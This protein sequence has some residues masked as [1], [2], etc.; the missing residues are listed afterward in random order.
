VLVMCTV[1]SDI[2]GFGNCR[3]SSESRLSVQDAGIAL[4]AGS[5]DRRASKTDLARQRIDAVDRD[6][7]ATPGSPRV[8]AQRQHRVCSSAQGTSRRWWF[9]LAWDVIGQCTGVPLFRRGNLAPGFAPSCH[10]DARPN[11]PRS[12][13][14][15]KNT[16]PR[17]A[18]TPNAAIF[19]WR[20][21]V[22]KRGTSVRASLATARPP[23]Y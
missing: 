1:R 19:P 20:A 16:R 8:A 3:N 21:M 23:H 9:C 14:A 13:T 22:E 11:R 10:P 7:P 4:A 2:S 12:G 17:D 5:S 15:T 6:S 18:T